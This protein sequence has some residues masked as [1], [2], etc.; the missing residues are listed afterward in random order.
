MEFLLTRITGLTWN[1]IFTIFSLHSNKLSLS[2]MKNRDQ[3][4]R[5]NCIIL[6]HCRNLNINHESLHHAGF[7][8]ARKSSI[9]QRLSMHHKMKARILLNISSRKKKHWNFEFIAPWHS[10]STMVKL[11]EGD[12]WYRNPSLHGGSYF[13]FMARNN[14][15]KNSEKKSC[16]ITIYIHTKSLRDVQIIWT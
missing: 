4:S 12:F 10:S 15:G 16:M 5:T 6:S 3:L 11:S 14:L 9:R 2:N 8:F 13:I 1:F 7:W